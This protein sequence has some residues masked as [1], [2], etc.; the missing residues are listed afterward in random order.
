MKTY[1]KRSYVD[2]EY[3]HLLEDVTEMLE[4]QEYR[5]IDQEAQKMDDVIVLQYLI[6]W[7]CDELVR[8]SND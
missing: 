2:I 7:L 3:P 6:T 8:L 4:D 5:T 1:E